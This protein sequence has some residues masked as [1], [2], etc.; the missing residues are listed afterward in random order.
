MIFLFSRNVSMWLHRSRTDGE[1]SQ[2]RPT[3]GGSG[4]EAEACRS[5]RVR[6]GCPRDGSTSAS[7][8]FP[9]LDAA[10]ERPHRP[11]T[12]PVPGPSRSARAPEGEVGNMRTRTKAATVLA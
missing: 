10:P 6:A 4:D 12:R 5:P 3:Q 11:L 9:P 7:L 1:R 8:L 2:K